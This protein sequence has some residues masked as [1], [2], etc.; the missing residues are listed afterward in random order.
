MKSNKMPAT[1]ENTIYNRVTCPEKTYCKLLDLRIEMS[2][3]KERSMGERRRL[4]DLIDSQCIYG[5]KRDRCPIISGEATCKR[6][7]E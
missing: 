7:E 2:Q 1:K 6:E 3:N 5:T 4:G